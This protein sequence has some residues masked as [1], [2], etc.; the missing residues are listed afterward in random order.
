MG[1]SQLPGANN[2]QY[3]SFANL[4]KKSG[5][6]ENFVPFFLQLILEDGKAQRLFLETWWSLGNFQCAKKIFFRDFENS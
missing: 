1:A 2:E 4:K 3:L 5:F 6:C